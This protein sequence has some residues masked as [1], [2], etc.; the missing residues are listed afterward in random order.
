MIL[1]NNLSFTVS[2]HFVFYVIFYLILY[3][4]MKSSKTFCLLTF[5]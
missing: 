2:P 4:K 3:E 5:I 1:S